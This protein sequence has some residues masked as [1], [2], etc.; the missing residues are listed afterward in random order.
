MFFQGPNKDK[1]LRAECFDTSVW[2]EFVDDWS[3]FL[4][5]VW[6]NFDWGWAKAEFT[7]E[8]DLEVGDW[9]VLGINEKDYDCGQFHWGE[10]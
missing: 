1:S 4:E 3:W 6:V 10:I 2:F 5:K 9:F 8:L 7:I